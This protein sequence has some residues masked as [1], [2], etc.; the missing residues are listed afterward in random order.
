ATSWARRTNPRK[1]PG[2]QRT[3]RARSALSTGNGPRHL[4]TARRPKAPTMT[5]AAPSPRRRF[6]LPF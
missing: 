5:P 3:S 1:C 6:R 4:R 2:S